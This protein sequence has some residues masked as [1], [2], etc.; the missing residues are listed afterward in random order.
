P[1]GPFWSKSDQGSWSIPTGIAEPGDPLTSARREFA[2]ETGL[3]VDGVF[4]SLAPV[5]QKSGKLLQT[6]AIEADLNLADFRGNAFSVEW[7]PGSGQLQTFPE[8]DRLEYFDLHVA[9]RKMLPYQWP[10]LLELSEK[11][12]WRIR[13]A[14]RR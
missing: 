2:K 1:G 13:R 12:G 5:E 10:L 8:I 3:A 7:P 6:F 14:H 9:L 11:Q 4:I